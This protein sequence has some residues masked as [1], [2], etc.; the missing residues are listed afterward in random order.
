MALSPPLVTEEVMIT[1][2]EVDGHRV[3]I[4]PNWVGAEFFQTMGIPL[5]RGRYFARRIAC[6]RD[7]RIPCAQAL[8]EPGP[9]RQALEEW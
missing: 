1:G 9:H 6:G 4:Y 5:L 7:Q 3:L 8:A 2:I